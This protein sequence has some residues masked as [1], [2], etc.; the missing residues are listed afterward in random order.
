MFESKKKKEPKITPVKSESIANDNEQ[1]IDEAGDTDDVETDS[2]EAVC[3]STELDLLQKELDQMTENWQRERASFQN[4]K[5][6]VEDEKKEIRKYASFDFAV[7]IVRV[8]DYFESSVTFEKNLP[9]EAQSVIIGVKYTLTELTRVLAAN[10]IHPVDVE[11]GQQFDSVWMQA[12]ESRPAEGNVAGTVLEVL[13][14]GWRMHDR[15]M[16]PARVVVAESKVDDSGNSNEQGGE[17]TET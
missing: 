14:R 7:E 17:L 16:R 3:D 1:V 8:I 2:P 4:F 6:R 5:R 12:V 13:Q 10:G 11:K 15:V 9:E